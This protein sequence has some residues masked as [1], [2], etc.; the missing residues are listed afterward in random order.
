MIESDGELVL[1]L[2]CGRQFE[3]FASVQLRKVRAVW[4]NRWN[5][6]LRVASEPAIIPRPAS[7]ADQ[8]ITGV[9]FAGMH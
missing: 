2:L 5:K 9:E 8:T 6:G 7:M 1:D 4:R 3:S